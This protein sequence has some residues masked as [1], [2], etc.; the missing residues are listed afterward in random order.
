M[1]VERY[2]TRDIKNS[3][4][5]LSSVSLKCSAQFSSTNAMMLCKQH[6]ILSVIYTYVRVFNLNKNSLAVK[7]ARPIRSCNG[8]DIN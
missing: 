8:S 1:P 6:V 5:T 3:I 7:S 4:L 2:L